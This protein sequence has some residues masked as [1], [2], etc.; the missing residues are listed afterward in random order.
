MPRPF[1]GVPFARVL[2]LAAALVCPSACCANGTCVK[3]PPCR[4]CEDP[5]CLTPIQRKALAGGTHAIQGGPIAYVYED[6]TYVLFTERGQKEFEKDPDAF[7]EKG[8]IRVIRSDGTWRVDMNPGDD[9]EF[10]P[11]AENAR[12]YSKAAPK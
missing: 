8:A 11:L 4:P 3:D 9:V 7:A 2:V 1:S 10:G 12:P 6:K 5:C